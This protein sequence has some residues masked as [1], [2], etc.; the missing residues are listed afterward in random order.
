[1]NAAALLRAMPQKS[2]TLEVIIV[3]S[4]ASNSSARNLKKNDN[5]REAEGIG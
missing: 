5:L 2:S 3:F 1:M 4:A